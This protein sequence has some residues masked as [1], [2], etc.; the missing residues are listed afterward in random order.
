MINYGF[1]HE[2]FVELPVIHINNSSIEAT[3]KILRI[4]ILAK[5][6]WVS[7]KNLLH[8]RFVIY[9]QKTTTAFKI[10]TILMTV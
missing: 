6:Q 2:R 9:Y 5:P 1:K 7:Q 3:Y 8:I 4:L 10:T